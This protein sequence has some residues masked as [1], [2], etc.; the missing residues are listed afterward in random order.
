MY[1]CL[2]VLMTLMSKQYY[3][4]RNYA[5]QKNVYYKIFQDIITKIDL[6]DRSTSSKLSNCK[7]PVPP[8]ATDYCSNASDNL[9]VHQL[10]KTSIEFSKRNWSTDIS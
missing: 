9:I 4:K 1:L 5:Y 2:G 8:E 3:G 7:R 10:E 6:E